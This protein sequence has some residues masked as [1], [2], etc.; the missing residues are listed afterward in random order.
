MLQVPPALKHFLVP[1]LGG[2]LVRT[3]RKNYFLHP[4]LEAETHTHGGPETQLRARMG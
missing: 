3:L 1:E 2:M 4:R